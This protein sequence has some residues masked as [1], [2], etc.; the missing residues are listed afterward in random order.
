MDKSAMKLRKIGI[1][2][3]V[4]LVV[5]ALAGQAGYAA[6]LHAGGQ[7]AATF[8]RAAQPNTHGEEA[9]KALNWMRTQQ[10]PDGSFAGFGAA[11]T[12]DALLAI[13]AA[14]ADPASFN[15]DGKTP[16]DF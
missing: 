2:W 9:Q 11:S 7:S 15:K 12:E 6:T 3:L 10:Q 1:A 13:I 8:A 14:G 4:G 16:V 5:F